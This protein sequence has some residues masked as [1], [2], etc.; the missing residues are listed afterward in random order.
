M[1]CK[2]NQQKKCSQDMWNSARAHVYTKRPKQ[3][4]FI[5]FGNTYPFRLDLKIDLSTVTI[6][7]MTIKYEILR[8]RH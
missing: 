2:H 7:I 3:H 1:P 6:C 4:R 5:P 8:N